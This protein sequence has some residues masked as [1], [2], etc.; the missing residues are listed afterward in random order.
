MAEVTGEEMVDRMGGMSVE[1]MDEGM[2]ENFRRLDEVL[3]ELPPG[4][5]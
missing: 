2:D 1:E 4:S 5:P 3:A